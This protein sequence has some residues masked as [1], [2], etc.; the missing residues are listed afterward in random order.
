MQSQSCGEASGCQLRFSGKKTIV[1]LMANDG[2]QIT[3][4]WP[5]DEPLMVR[6]SLAVPASSL[7]RHRRFVLRHTLLLRASS[8]VILFLVT[9]LVLPAAISTPT[10]SGP[11]LNPEKEGAEL[12]QKLRAMAPQE[13]SK[14]RGVLN[15]QDK[16]RKTREVPVTC[17]VLA[18][19]KTWQVS[20]EAKTSEGSA[21]EKLMILHAADRPN[22]Y[23]YTK[24]G[25]SEPQ[26][27]T[28][29]KAMVAF[30]GSDFWLADL[31]LEFLHWPK[32]QL[33]KT[34]M[35]KSRWCSVLQS[36]NP[37]AKG[38]GYSRVISWI[39]K[40][41]GG[42]ILADAYDATGKKVKEFS[43]RSL[44]KVEGEYQ[45]EEMQIQSLEKKSRTRL[46]FDL[47]KR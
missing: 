22:E 4:E 13:N 38:R 43:I 12:A 8:F 18:G 42:P 10:T 2:P 21:P 1:K 41:S 7:F 20:Y 30:A 44:K 34:E 23:L 9:G 29:D 25:D 45:L 17:Q 5:N 27:L 33:L 28:G 39:D 26:K 37:G 32:Q 15:I 24:P 31:G 14:A 6:R 46:E 40:E 19:G 47:E 11:I 35:R 36:E 16:E 3:K